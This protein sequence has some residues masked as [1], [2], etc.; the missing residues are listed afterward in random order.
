MLLTMKTERTINRLPLNRETL[1][2]LTPADLRLVAGGRRNNCT[3]K[4]SGCIS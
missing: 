4:Y 3:G 2:V 1:R